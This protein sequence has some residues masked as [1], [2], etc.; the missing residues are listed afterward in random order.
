MTPIVAATYQ[1]ACDI[2]YA[3]HLPREQWCFVQTKH[4]A[5]GRRAADGDI[6]LVHVGLPL[7]ES[8][9]EAIK[10]ME[11]AGYRKEEIRL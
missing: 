4:T 3:R 2:A 6:M 7:S 10:Y 11:L 1:I 8:Q 5:Y 9:L